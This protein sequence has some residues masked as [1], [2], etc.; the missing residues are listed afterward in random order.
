[1]PDDTVT[2]HRVQLTE[3]C[4][5]VFRRAL[6]NQL[7]RSDQTPLRQAFQVM[8]FHQISDYNNRT[9]ATAVARS[10]ANRLCS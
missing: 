2:N 1:M 9:K 10:F 5:A 4:L 6:S 7:S 3:H 8:D